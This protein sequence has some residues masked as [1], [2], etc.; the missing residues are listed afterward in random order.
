MLPVEFPTK[1][2]DN[3]PRVP[4]AKKSKC[5]SHDQIFKFCKRL[6]ITTL[7]R[8]RLN[9]P[10]LLC[11]VICKVLLQNIIPS[12][13]AVLLKSLLLQGTIT[14]YLKNLTFL[15]TSWIKGNPKTGKNISS[16]KLVAICSFQFTISSFFFA[17]HLIIIL[18]VLF[19][20][21]GVSRR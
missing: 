4:I 18:I 12:T 3:L 13:I 20:Y 8:K 11:Q 1:Y 7:L 9:S 14:R 21:L 17:L 6:T 19:L 2:V 16:C 15:R 10:L 5:E